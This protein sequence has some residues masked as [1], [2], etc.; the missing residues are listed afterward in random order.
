VAEYDGEQR[1]MLADL[2]WRVARADGWA[3]QHEAFLAAKLEAWLG[4]RGPTR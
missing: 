3:D 1:Q 2:L 4:V